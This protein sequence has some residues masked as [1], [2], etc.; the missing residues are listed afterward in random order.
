MSL[1]IRFGPSWPARI[2]FTE[3][4]RAANSFEKGRGFAVQTTGSVPQRHR[5]PCTSGAG[6]GAC[7]RRSSSAT[8]TR[9]G[10]TARPERSPPRRHQA[11]EPGSAHRGRT[12]HRIARYASPRRTELVW[13]RRGSPCRRR[14]RS[15]RPR[16][17]PS[18]RIERDIG[19]DRADVAVVLWSGPG[20]P[21]RSRRSAMHRRS[22]RRWA[23]RC[24]T[25]GDSPGLPRT[26]SP[27]RWE[28]SVTGTRAGGAAGPSCAPPSVR[29][30]Q[31]LARSRFANGEQAYALMKPSSTASVTC[32]VRPTSGRRRLDRSAVSQRGAEEVSRGGDAGAAPTDVDDQNRLASPTAAPNIFAAS[33]LVRLCS[34]H[35]LVVPEELL[36]TSPSGAG[37]NR[38]RSMS[39]LSRTAAGSRTRCRSG[40]ARWSWCRCWTP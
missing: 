33:T 13:R 17:P 8:R 6:F 27:Q 4:P 7:R 22:A 2:T 38:N 29:R 37:R 26:L 18:Q 19:R 9:R 21:R 23:E 5:A 34:D 32:S 35:V 16:S 24:S 10:A 36:Q 31:N 12:G 28:V 14:R 20:T 40:A 11:R 25:E 1:S 15:T 30:H 39:A 3:M